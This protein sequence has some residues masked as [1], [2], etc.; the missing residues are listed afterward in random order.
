M[1]GHTLLQLSQLTKLYEWEPG[2][3][4][5]DAHMHENLQLYIVATAIY[6]SNSYI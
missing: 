4:N 5:Y 2:E 3:A 1:H 6:S